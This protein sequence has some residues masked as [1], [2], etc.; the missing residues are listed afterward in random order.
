MCSSDLIVFSSGS[1]NDSLLF[2]GGLPGAS[3]QVTNAGSISFGSKGA[4]AIG[5][6]GNDSVVFTNTGA[7]SLTAGSFQVAYMGNVY[8]KYVQ[9]GSASSFASAGPT[10]FAY[11]S[12][13]NVTAGST[14]GTAGFDLQGGS[15]AVGGTSGSGTYLIFGGAGGFTGTQSGGA[16][17]VNRPGNLALFI[18]Q[19]EI[20]RA[21][22]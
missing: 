17:T 2:E 18:G 1:N 10:L 13:A 12:L 3:R 11:N 22:V 6:T 4:L 14:A 16:L 8:G 20:G 7:I 9:S 5:V 21:H 19:D 15:F